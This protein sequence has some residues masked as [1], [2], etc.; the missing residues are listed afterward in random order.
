MSREKKERSARNS[1]K[2]ELACFTYKLS[3]ALPPKLA[4]L[5]QH[6]R[7]PGKLTIDINFHSNETD[8]LRVASAYECDQTSYQG[9]HALG[10]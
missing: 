9:D 3:A 1:H 2:V 7:R 8:N 5:V 10:R 4:K 6:Y